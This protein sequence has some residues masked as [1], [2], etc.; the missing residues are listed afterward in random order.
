[1]LHLFYGFLSIMWSTAWFCILSTD[2]VKVSENP[3]TALV[4]SSP[5]D[6]ALLENCFFILATLIINYSH[7]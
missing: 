3:I 1:M 5:R 4:M 2:E 7:I 6:M